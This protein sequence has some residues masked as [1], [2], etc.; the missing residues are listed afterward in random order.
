MR[1]MRYLEL[2]NLLQALVQPVARAHSRLCSQASRTLLQ[3]HVIAYFE[4]LA[5]IFHASTPSD[6]SAFLEA[7]L[8]YIPRAGVD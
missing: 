1:R 5:S 6:A 3:E 2:P 4:G 7:R 8:Q